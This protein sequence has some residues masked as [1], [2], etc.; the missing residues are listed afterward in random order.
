M[1]DK[2]HETARQ[3]IAY[4]LET[5]WFKGSLEYEEDRFTA[6][7]TTNPPVVVHFYEDELFKNIGDDTI[8]EY[9]KEKLESAQREAITNAAYEYFMTTCHNVAK[10]ETPTLGKILGKTQTFTGSSPV[11]PFSK[12]KLPSDLGRK[13]FDKGK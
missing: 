10:K 13:L 2:Q 11:Q 8:H 3:F 4:C 12:D 5:L 1:M 6:A 7:S 9:F